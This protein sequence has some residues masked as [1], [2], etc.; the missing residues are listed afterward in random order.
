MDECL[1]CLLIELHILDKSSSKLAKTAGG[2]VWGIS[3]Y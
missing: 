2:D 1:S 3:L